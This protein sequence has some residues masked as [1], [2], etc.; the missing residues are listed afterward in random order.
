MGGATPGG[1]FDQNFPKG[2]KYHNLGMERL[3]SCMLVNKL[4]GENTYHIT[5]GAGQRR[6]SFSNLFT[7]NDAG[8]GYTGAGGAASSLHCVYPTR[9]PRCIDYSGALT[10]LLQADMH[11]AEGPPSPTCIE[12]V[13]AQSCPLDAD[14]ACGSSKVQRDLLACCDHD[15]NRA[16]TCLGNGHNRRLGEAIRYSKSS[17]VDMDAAVGCAHACYQANN[18]GGTCDAW[19]LTDSEECVLALKCYPATYAEVTNLKLSNSRWNLIKNA[20]PFEGL[21]VTVRQLKI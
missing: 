2:F 11:C 16:S 5:V 18:D 1:L 20:K 13:L 21:V 14:T 19:R 3:P 9:Q 7:P 17:V 12:T 8:G 10:G 4:P 6:F 15:N